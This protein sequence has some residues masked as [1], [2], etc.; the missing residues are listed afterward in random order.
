VLGGAGFLG[1]HLAEKLLQKGHAVRV[2]DRPNA[3]RDNLAAVA[4][5]VEFLG[6]D[7]SNQTDLELALDGVKTVYHLISTTIPS[8]SNENPVYDV[9]TNLVPTL[10]LLDASLRH[11]VDRIVFLSSGGTVYGK[12]ETL[13]IQET[14]NTEPQVSYG[15]IKLTIERYLALYHRLHKLSSTIIRLANPYGPRQNPDAPQGAA[16][17][18]LGKAAQGKPIQIWGDGGVVRDYIYVDDAVRGVMAAA[19]GPSSF[20]A[21]NIGSGVGVS[22]KELIEGIEKVS[23]RKLDVAYTH[24]RPFDVPANVLDISAAQRDLNWKPEVGLED[25]LKR[26]WDWLRATLGERS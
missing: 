13:P 24:G 16:A 20:A 23:D 6:G 14:H 9:E 21:Y 3:N 8:T 2:F 19:N 25:G 18:F 7:F 10:H 22:L 4:G 15:L 17:V 5:D 1:S 26:T 11:K 12:P